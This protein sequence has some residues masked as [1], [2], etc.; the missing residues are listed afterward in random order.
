[1]KRELVV[2][3]H[4]DFEQLIQHEQD[5]GVEFWLARDLQGL[6]GYAKW[7]NFFKVIE[8]A[9][10]ACQNAGYSVSDH[11]LDVRKM[12]DIGSGA[13]RPLDDIAPGTR[14]IRPCRVSFQPLT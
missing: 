2:K 4:G 11:F 5:S 7:E 14:I 3:L 8:K 12:V 6:L 1:M 9:R 10:S 13:Q